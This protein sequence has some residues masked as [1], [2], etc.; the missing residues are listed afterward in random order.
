M[1]KDITTTQNY[2]LGLTATAYDI[3]ALLSRGL[4]GQRSRFAHVDAWSGREEDA[5][6]RAAE[7]LL[8]LYQNGALPAE[9]IARLGRSMRS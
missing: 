8:P 4:A 7:E 5:I 1:D 2:R 6:L 9:M 3:A